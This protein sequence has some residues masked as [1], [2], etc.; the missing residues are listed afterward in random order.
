M[1][2]KKN[3]KDNKQNK[4]HPIIN[5]NNRLMCVDVD[6]YYINCIHI[7]Q[8]RKSDDTISDVRQSAKFRTQK[9][10]REKKTIIGRTNIFPFYR[11][12]EYTHA[13]GSL[14]QQKHTKTAKL[15]TNRQR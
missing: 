12:G 5:R 4:E 7:R 15:P 9:R 13:Q 11:N 3:A 1:I 10:R 8:L 6:K 2:P 14:L